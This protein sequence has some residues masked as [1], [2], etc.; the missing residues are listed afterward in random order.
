MKS[1]VF[2]PDLTRFQPWWMHMLTHQRWTFSFSFTVYSFGRTLCTAPSSARVHRPVTERCGCWDWTENNAEEQYPQSPSEITLI[3][4]VCV[5]VGGARL[6]V[7]R[8]LERFVY[9]CWK[10][11]LWRLNERRSAALRLCFCVSDTSVWTWCRE[12]S[13]RWLMKT[14]SACQTFIRW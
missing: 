9:L 14:R 6:C 12:R 2:K 5:C 10:C 3:Y 11:F 1:L 13:L 4:S 8:W 7:Q